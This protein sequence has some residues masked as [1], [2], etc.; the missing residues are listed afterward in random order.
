MKKQQM[1]AKLS[2]AIDLITERIDG[3][4]SEEKELAKANKMLCDV[5]K[6]LKKDVD[7]KP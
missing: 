6:E 3:Y 7:K 1:L 5:Y 4:S 2:T